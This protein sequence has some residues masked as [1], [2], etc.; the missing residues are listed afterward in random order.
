M[1]IDIW[2]EDYWEM[3]SLKVTNMFP[4]DCGKEREEI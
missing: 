4:C 1:W 2:N 3:N